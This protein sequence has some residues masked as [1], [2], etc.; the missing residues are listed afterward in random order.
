LAVSL[1]ARDFLG[2]SVT[3]YPRTDAPLDEL[4]RLGASLARWLGDAGR[5]EGFRLDPC[6]LGHVLRRVESL[7]AGELPDPVGLAFANAAREG[8]AGGGLALSLGAIGRSAFLRARHV[9][10]Q[11]DDAIHR[12]GALRASLSGCLNAPGVERVEF[13]FLTPADVDGVAF[14]EI[15]WTP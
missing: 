11:V 9:S 10:F 1:T 3:V 12:L 14:T 8:A 7:V 5:R 6:G 2:V 15:E 13:R 4:K